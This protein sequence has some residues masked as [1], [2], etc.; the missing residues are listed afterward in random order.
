MKKLWVL[1]VFFLCFLPYCAKESNR[2][3]PPLDINAIITII[4]GN[5]QTGQGGTQLADPV[6]VQVTDLGQNPIP[7]LEVNFTVVEG[8]GTIPN[9]SIVTTDASGMASVEWI[10]G[11]S[12]N[13]IEVSLSSD[14]FNAAA[15]YICAVGENPSGIHITRTISSLRNVEGVLYEITFYGNYQS[16]TIYREFNSTLSGNSYFC[17]LFAVFGDPQHYLLGR[18]FENPAGWECLTLLT[19]VNPSD[20]YASIAPMRMRDIGFGPGTDFD[21]VSFVEKNR[22]LDAIVNPPDGINEHGLVLGLANVTPQPY[23]RD[24]NKQN[25]TCVLMVRKILD[26]ARTVEEA[27]EIALSYNIFGPDNTLDIHAIVADTTGRS[28]ILEPADGEMK[29][30]PNTRNFQVMTNSPIHNVSLDT[31]FG[32]CWRFRTIYERLDS[33]NGILNGSE[34]VALLQE[35]GNQWT[36]WSAVYNISRESA[37]L[38]IDFNFDALYD[39]FL[40]PLWE[41]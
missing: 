2:T 6:V 4:S 11:S 26:H 1:L 8:S 20:G 31:L 18:S 7:N 33:E 14:S 37:T 24:P 32:Q 5:H 19:R 27:A 38:A 41:K 3:Q 22:L 17:S 29:V 13:G 25:I 9:N 36:E 10:I 30:I 16:D 39:F 12:Y 15:N 28:I 21:S 34:A 23:N 35:V 40:F